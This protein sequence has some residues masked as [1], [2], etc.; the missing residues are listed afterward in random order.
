M[1]NELTDLDL[2]E[3]S[4][5]IDPANE[6]STIEIVKS[7][8]GLAPALKE[9]DMS[10]DNT[11]Q[12]DDI[13]T[14]EGDADFEAFASEHG[15]AICNEFSELSEDEQAL[16]LIGSQYEAAIADAAIADA[17]EVVKALTENTVPREK[18]NTLLKSASAAA[19]L[20]EKMKTKGHVTAEEGGLVGEIRKAN[21]DKEL[22]PEAEA[23][24]TEVEKSL[25]ATARKEAIAKAREWGFGHPETLADIDALIRKSSPE[26]AEKFVALVKQAAGIAK[27]SPLFK[28]VGED[29]GASDGELTPIAKM[30]AKA[31]EI[32][33]ADT[34][35]TDQ[36]AMTK[37][38]EQNP[39]LYTE[40]QRSLGSGQRAA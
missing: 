30:K 40:Y 18:Y 6:D 13:D 1:A 5:C 26:L 3:W 9:T 28:S 11:D 29:A 10:A 8:S 34:A 23:R 15:D 39:T 7:K 14:G 22:S 2:G 19:D 21:G 27:A 20:I 37:A 35:L 31:D 4:I 25:A 24:I 16:A 32:K 17:T 38:I 12:N 33:K 36:Q